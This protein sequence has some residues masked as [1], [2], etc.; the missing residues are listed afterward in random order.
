MAQLP[1]VM[2]EVGGECPAAPC[3]STRR[4]RWLDAKGIK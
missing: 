4:Y 1:L 2:Y 3:S